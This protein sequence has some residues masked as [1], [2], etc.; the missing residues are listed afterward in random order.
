MSSSNSVGER[1]L[2][3]GI[4]GCGEIV[5]VAHIPNINFL[6]H[7]FRTTYL[8]DISKDAL[9]HSSTKVNGSVP[10]TTTDPEILCS[11]DEVDVV[12]IANADAYHVEHG[13]LALKNDKYC[14][15][16]KPAAVCFRDLDKL[17]EAEKSSKGKVFVG[18][19]RRFAT[20]FI[21][22]VQEVGGLD[23]I[24]YARVR[25]II[26]PN[27]VFVD[28]S[29]TFPQKFSDFS[30]SDTQDRL[31]REDDIQHQALDKE[32]GVP[33]TPESKRM[34]RLLGAL[35]THDLSAMRE[36]LGMPRGVSGAMLTFP[37]IFS[38]LFDYG[39]FPVT[40]ESGL[41]NVP[42][43]DAHIEVYSADKIVRVEFDTPFVK[44]LPTLMIIKEKVGEG[45]FQERSVR[46][47]Y[48]DA[49]TLELK[50]LHRC[51]LEGESPKTS[52]ADARN[53]IELF[54]MILQ[55]GADRYR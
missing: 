16:E 27:S 7:L 31:K 40:Y 45:G 42:E 6:S 29:G 12:L 36:I 22:A 35:G 28:Q 11:S 23:K 52:A 53:D 15:I 46:K 1:V 47:T 2:R 38:I 18:T 32:F 30:D 26:G 43:F 20:A 55:A 41:I 48:E 24:L 39:S 49:Y 8:C 3:V 10:K 44:G 25:D 34:L 54:R 13:L 37:G 50:E 5:Q 9:A 51:V 33:V 21:D 4:I 14:L 19:M 17:L